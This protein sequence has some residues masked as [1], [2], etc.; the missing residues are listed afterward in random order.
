MKYVRLPP[1]YVPYILRV[2]IDAETP[3]SI[4]GVFKTNSPLDG[5]RFNRARFTECKYVNYS[6]ICAYTLTN[7]IFKLPSDFSKPI[8]I[9]LPIS[10]AGALVFW[11]EYG[12]L[13]SQ[14][15][16]G[17]EGYFNVDPVLRI[18]ARSPILSSGLSPLPPSSGA[19]L[20]EDTVNLPLDGLLILAAVSKWMGPMS[21]WRNHFA[22]A[23]DRGYTMLPPPCKNVG[24][25]TTLTRFVINS[26]TTPSMFDGKR[27][28]DGDCHG[29][30]KNRLTYAR[31]DENGPKLGE[32]T[33]ANPL[34]ETYLT[35]CGPKPDSDPLVYFLANN[36]WI[37]AADPLKNSAL[38]PSKAY[39]GHEVIVWGD[40]D[41]LRCGSGPEDNPWLWSHITSYI[42]SLAATFDGFRVD[43]RHSTPLHVGVSMLDAA[44]VV[45][46]DL[47][48][49]W[50]SIVS[51]GWDAKEYSRLL[52][53]DVGKTDEAC[54]T[55]TEEIP[56]PTGKGPFYTT[57]RTITN[58]PFTNRSVKGFDDLYPKLLNLVGEKRK[59]E[60]TGLQEESGFAKNAKDRGYGAHVR[61]KFIITSYD[62]P[63]DAKTLKG[64]PHKLFEMSPVVVPQGLDDEIPY[65]E[66]IVPEYFPPGSIEVFANLGL[67]ELNVVLFRDGEERD[68]TNGQFGVYDVPG[69]GRMT[70]CG[71]EGWMHPL[72]LIMR[73]NDLGHPLC[74]HL[75]KGTWSL[76]YDYNRLIQAD[77]FS[78]L[79]NVAQW[80]KDRFDRI[81]ATAPPFLHPNYFALVISEAYKAAHRSVVEQCSEFVLTGHDF[82]LNLAL[83]AIQMY[84][85]VKQI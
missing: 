22:E 56:S 9:D 77:D 14:R 68:A 67:V 18:K 11:V 78:Y 41:K 62:V 55:S 10:H 29:Y 84:G 50:E 80:F 42:T 58:L 3:A 5:G 38:L 19:V 21:E 61:A 8:Q 16:K 48:V 82:T 43:N 59:Y 15:I 33:K 52:Y 85:M 53:R 24:K 83:C 72:R 81:K 26:N 57:S 64:L 37:W 2:S 12:E 76:N 66:I 20:Q 4:N 7:H 73:N 13:P 17:R 60:V 27:Q 47:Y 39:L 31:L 69:L 32:I 1:A 25:A 74:K 79:K 54:L 6:V 71:L 34:V 65:S 49:C 75:R 23:K 51:Y 28:A 40:C 30:I 45:K 35:R 36:S 44:R 70:Y 63:V 46:P